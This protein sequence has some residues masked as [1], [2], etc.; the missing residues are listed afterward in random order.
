MTKHFGDLK[1]VDNISFSLYEKQI[2]CLLG[3]NGA[4]KTTTINLLTGMLSLT[5]G[6]TTIYG[7]DIHEDIEEIRK[8]LGLCV[9]KDILYEEFTVEEHL[10][11]YASIKGIA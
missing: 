7:M 6:T 10:K 8:S 9:Q 4:G 3:H 11:F 5:G 2:F 1:A